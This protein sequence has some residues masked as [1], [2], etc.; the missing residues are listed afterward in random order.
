VI[1]AGSCGP[2]T[3]ALARELGRL[4]ARDGCEIVCG[5]LQGVMRAACQGAREAGG[6]TIGILPGDRPEDANEFVDVAIAT[7]LGHMRNY[8]VVCNGDIAVAVEGG[9]GT[10]SELAL[11][12]KSGKTVIAL[13]AWSRLEELDVVPA[14]DAAH[15]AALVREHLGLE[16]RNP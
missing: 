15:A 13:G 12:R 8:L 2:E 1:G 4:L 7:C 3:E 11:A 9:A 10:L 5:G 14:R 6:R 16:E